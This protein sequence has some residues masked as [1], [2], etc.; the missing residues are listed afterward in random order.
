MPEWIIVNGARI[1]RSFF[2]EN[3]AEARSC[4]W[5]KTVWEDVGNHGHCMICGVPLCEGESCL[6]SKNGWLCTYCFDTFVNPTDTT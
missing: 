3:V 5:L 6:R 2:Q 4:A 1:E